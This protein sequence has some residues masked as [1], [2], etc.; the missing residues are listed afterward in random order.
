MA[1]GL[2]VL[3]KYKLFQ[4]SER[5]RKQLIIKLFIMQHIAGNKK[6]PRVHR[7]LFYV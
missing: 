3:Q 7:D 6:D 2:K 4:V 5:N 1:A